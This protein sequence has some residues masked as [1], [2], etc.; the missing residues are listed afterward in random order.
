MTCERAPPV[1]RRANSRVTVPMSQVVGPATPSGV[2]FGTLVASD[3]P[4]IV[5]ERAIYGNHDGV[6]WSAGSAALGTPLP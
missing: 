1:C 4:P 5:V 6:L 2:W 3:G